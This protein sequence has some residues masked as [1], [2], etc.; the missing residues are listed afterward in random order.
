MIEKKFTIIICCYNNNKYLKE[1]LLSVVNQKKNLLP[2]DIIFVDDKSTDGSLEIAKKIFFSFKNT[3][4]IENK[5]NI[6]LSKS[7]NKAIK[8]CKTK[9]FI[10]VDSDDFIKSNTLHYFEK[11]IEKNY[12]CICCNRIEF[13]KKTKKKAKNNRNLFK[14]ISCGVA[15]KTNRVKKI[16]GYK[17]L[18]WEEYDLY[19][20]Y[21]NNNLDNIVNI[22]QYLYFYRKHKSSMSYKKNWVKRAWKQLEKKYGQK[23]LK[24]YKINS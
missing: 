10:R 18:L 11:K 20:R 17:N 23:K 24:I 9:Y 22:D 7:C 15:L 12:D 8:A 3:K 5:K 1:C 14:M 21:L 2:Y 6:G 19:I 13:N 4:I 16:G